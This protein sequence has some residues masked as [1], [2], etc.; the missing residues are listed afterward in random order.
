MVEGDFQ[1]HGRR[2]STSLIAHNVAS[3]LHF[4]LLTF[5]MIDAG[6]LFGHA[7]VVQQLG[8]SQSHFPECSTSNGY[9]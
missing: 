3:Q 5:N 8:I 9:E 6:L 7:V 4:Y 1:T 2:E